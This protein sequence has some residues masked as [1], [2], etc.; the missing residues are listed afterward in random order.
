MNK[1]AAVLVLASIC[2]AGVSAQ[3]PRIVTRAQWGARAASTSQLPIRPA[4]WVVMHHTAGAH[5]TTDAACAQ[6]MRNIQSFHM[7]GNGWADIG[8]N[9]LV[10][11]NGAAYEG[12]GWGRQGAHAPGYN[13]R[14]VGM[15]VMGTF[16][17]GIPNAAARNAA[18]QLISCGVS[19]GH[20]AS[21]YWL[22]GHRQAVA[23]ACP[24]NAFFNEIRNWPRFNPNV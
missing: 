6:Q 22:I 9:F 11:E 19:L 16:T 4:P 10:G 17:N 8:Y 14:S 15:G 20:I 12:R 2:L 13:D 3:C 5:C 1:F 7:D 21:N 23:T 24:G 18:Q